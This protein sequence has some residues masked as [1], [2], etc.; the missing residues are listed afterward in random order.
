MKGQGLGEY[1]LILVLVVVVVFLALE[2]TGTSIPDLYCKVLNAFNFN[3]G[4]A[5]GSSLLDGFG[6]MAD[7]TKFWGGGNWTLAGGQLCTAG[8]MR[9]LNKSALPGDY[10]INLKDAVLNSGNGYGAL[11]RMAKSGT[12]YSGYG[13]MVD[14]G[15]NN[16]FTFRKYTIDGAEISPPLAAVKFPAGFNPGIAHDI[17]V[18]LTGSTFTAYVDGVQVLTANDSA[19]TSGQMGVRSI[20][21][22]NA[23]INGM[24]VTTP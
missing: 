20:V 8:D 17:K 22:A 6:K 4:S 24:T 1:A 9:I 14:P 18:S 21:N 3:G 23:C 12:G 7:W 19:Y 2:L 13:F 10:T 5:C 15:L 16:Q 11:F